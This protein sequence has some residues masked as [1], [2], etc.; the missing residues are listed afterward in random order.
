MLRLKRVNVSGK[1][2]LFS[3]KKAE[4]VTYAE[5]HAIFEVGLFIATVRGVVESRNFDSSPGMGE[6]TPTFEI[7][8]EVYHG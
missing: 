2:P 6:S 4:G 1:S 5:K 3:L 7:S 8:L